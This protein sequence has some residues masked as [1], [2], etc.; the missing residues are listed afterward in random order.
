MKFNTELIV[1]MTRDSRRFPSG[2]I[3][4]E[5]ESKKP[6]RAPD[7]PGISFLLNHIASLRA[8]TSTYNKSYELWRR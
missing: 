7:G 2:Q 8:V 4:M 5:R 3:S 6:I 1:L